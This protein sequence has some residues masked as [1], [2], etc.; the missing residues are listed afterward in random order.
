MFRSHIPHVSRLVLLSIAVGLLASSALFAQSLGPSGAVEGTVSDPSGAVVAGAVVTISNPVTGYKASATVDSQGRFEL[1]KVPFNHYHLLVTAQDFNTLQQDIDLRTTVPLQLKLGMTVATSNTTVQVEASAEDLIESTPTAHTDIDKAL[2]ERLPG[3]NNNSALSSIIT[4]ATPGVVQDSNGM[5]HP[6][7]EHADTTFSIDNQPISDQQSRVFSNQLSTNAIQSMEVVS[8]VPPAEFGDKASLVVRTTTKSGLGSKPTGTFAIGYGSFGTPTAS[9]TLGLGNQKIGNFLSADG[10]SSGRFLDTPEFSPLHAHG[11]N[12]NFFDRLDYQ[13]SV[14]NTFHLNLFAARSWFQIPNDYTQQAAGQDQRQL[15]RS[16]NIAPGFTHLFSNS[17][18]LDASAWV[19]EDRVQYYPSAD[20]FSD[21]PATLA[22]NRRLLNT[23]IRADFSYVSGI[24]NAKFGV[25]VMHTLLSEAFNLGLTDAIF[26]APCL[27]GSGG[28]AGQ[29]VPAPAPTNPTLCSSYGYQ[30]NP[31]FQPGLLAFDLTR[32]GSLFDF[33]GRT[34]IK[35][36]AI[37]AQDSIAIRQ[38]TV[39][40]GLRADNYNGLSRRA[41]VEPRVGLSYLIKWSNTVLRASYGRIFLTPYNENLVLSST[42]GQGGLASNVF[43]AFGAR[44]L[45]PAERNQFNVGLQ[46][47][48]GRFLSINAEYFWKFTNDDYDFDVLFNTPLA[49]PIQWKKSKIDGL[50]L[51]LNFPEYHGLSAYSVMGHT[52]A[53]FFGPEVGGILFNSPVTASVFRIDHDQA[54]QQTTHFQYQPTKKAPWV[55]LTWTY[56][57]GEV[58]GS[59]PDMATALSLSGDEQAQIGLF[60]GTTFATVN[61]P[62]RSCSPAQFGSVRLRI[63]APGTQN[64]D[65]NPPRI[66]PRHLF[67]AAVGI[68]NLLRTEKYKLGL[69]FT[70]VNLTN[71]VALYNF[72]STFSGTHFVTPRSYQAQVSFGF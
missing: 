29:P 4:Q 9:V 7:G 43:G 11:N 65:A 50:S 49:F 48:V 15:V 56:E 66:A 18:L 46:Q 33:A 1:Q 2:L 6:Q 37:Y 23:G 3:D 25:Q 30:P 36:E 71:K 44:P 42:T 70:A 20:P 67:D 14:A 64:A 69:R 34:D 12:E 31:G 68:D 55:G 63:P 51:R 32:S 61:T 45:T 24:H 60:C 10:L 5:F 54:F 59:V 62:I 41:N 52:R 53:R 39:M 22:Q 26:N 58:A 13:Q 21:Q 47:A 38:F 40:L 16:F 27:Y 8:G 57:S 28:N 35:Q 72:L 17:S 19:R